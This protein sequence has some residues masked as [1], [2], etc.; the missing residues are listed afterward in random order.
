MN[1]SPGKINKTLDVIKLEGQLTDQGIRRLAIT[2]VNH[3]GLILVKVVPITSLLNAVKIG[4]GF[5]PVSDAFRIDGQIEQAHQLA[6]PDGDLR[7]K[8]VPDAIGMLE[9]KS[10]WC[11]M[12]GERWYQDGKQ[13]GVD[14]RS[15]CRRMQQDLIDIEADFKA[16]FELEWMVLEEEL[17]QDSISKIMGGPYG[18]DRLIDGL[19]YAAAITNA[20]EDAGVSWMQFHPEYGSSQFEI[21]LSPGTALQA[22][23]K[24]ILTKLIVQRITKKF[25]WRCSFSPKPKKNVVGNGAHLHMSILEKGNNLFQGGQMIAGLQVRGGSIIS[26]LL[27]N[28]PALMAL[29]CPS[30]I[31]YLRLK[32]KTWSAPYQIWGIE[33]REAALRLVPSV[34]DLS[35]AH[36]ELKVADATANPY[37]LVGSVMAIVYDGLVK[38]R[39]HLDPPIVG[40]PSKQ[41]GLEKKLLPKNLNESK[42]YFLRNHILKRSMGP[43]LHSTLV[44][45]MEAEERRCQYLTEDEIIS[46]TRLWPLLASF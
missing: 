3:S 29:G 15:F 7:L 35:D 31:S 22:C 13:Y 46:M 36:L 18:A 10:G 16:G 24:L 40:D 1:F 25:G 11:W 19:D 43:N 5:S 23:D 21:S 44:E 2:W 9:S 33:N 6:V 14:Q 8:A 37:L 41:K 45:S 12:P 38:Y 42:E 20:L 30:C 27:E 17:E 39:H 26:S 4:V 32:P 34:K 28:L